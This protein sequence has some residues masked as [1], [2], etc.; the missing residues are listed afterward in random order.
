MAVL[1][2]WK[3]STGMSLRNL[4]QAPASQFEEQEKVILTAVNEALDTF[5]AKP[6]FYKAF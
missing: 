2:E 1:D 3:K 4:L 5:V 6:G